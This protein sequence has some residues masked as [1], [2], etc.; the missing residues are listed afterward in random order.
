MIG[1]LTVDD[2]A[3]RSPDWAFAAAHVMSPPF[4]S[5]EHQEALW[6]GLSSGA[7]QTTGTDHCTFS[8]EQKANGK[9]NFT[10]IPNGCGGIEERMPVLWDAG[11]NGGK[12]TPSEFVRV[13][14]TGAAQA[15]NLYPRKGVVAAGADADLVVWDP[16]ATKTLSAKTQLSK[17]DFNVFEG[18][19]VRGLPSHTVCAGRVVYAKGDIRAEKGAGRYMKRPAGGPSFDALRKVAALK[20]PTAVKR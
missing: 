12:L 9:D 8:A 6:Q 20:T 18:R 2:S 17:G 13:T 4:R 19:K 11:V 5:K 7:L 1:H 3:Y 10:K 14:S 16:E 15:F